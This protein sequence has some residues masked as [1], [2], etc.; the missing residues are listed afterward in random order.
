MLSQGALYYDRPI[1][2]GGGNFRDPAKN[3]KRND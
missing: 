3:G 1:E 2:E